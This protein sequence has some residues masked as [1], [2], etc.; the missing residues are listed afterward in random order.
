MT[1]QTDHHT[2]AQALVDRQFAF[3]DLSHPAMAMLQSL[4]MTDTTEALASGALTPP[5]PGSTPPL[6][7]PQAPLN[8]IDLLRDEISLPSLPSVYAELQTVIAD[9]NSSASDVARVI[10]SDTS[11]TAF[12]LRLVNSAFYSFPSQIDTISRA[13]AVVGTA[14]L[15][16]LALGTSVMTMFTGIPEELTNMEDFWRH[17]ISVGVL[18]RAIAVRSATGEPERFFVAGLL[19]DVGRLALCKVAPDRFGDA[20]A[21]ARAKGMLLYEA[22]REALGVDHATLGGMLLRKWNLPFSL[23]NAVLY[24]HDPARASKPEA[25]AVIH[26]ADILSCALFHGHTTERLVPP[27]SSEAWDALRLSPDDLPA[28][29]NGAQGQ[30]DETLHALLHGGA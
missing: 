10:S 16:T 2:T 14:Q 3:A 17:S 20:I 6:P 29:V 5:K 7:E 26:L 24:H 22:E 9:T 25:S 30:I 18:A 23:V 4:A 19:H 1:T 12:L 15:S 8:A 21:T 28:C 27:L 13:V 11:L